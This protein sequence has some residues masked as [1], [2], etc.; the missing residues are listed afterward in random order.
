MP[1]TSRQ[2]IRHPMTIPIEF[3]LAGIVEKIHIKDIGR[4]G[5][6]FSSSHSIDTGE[7]IQIIIP[8]CTPEFDAKG[9]VCWCKEDGGAFLVGVSF[10]QE[11]VSYAVRMVEQVCHIEDYR[12][13]M[14]VEKGIELTSEQAA[15]QWISE[16]AQNFPSFLVE[17]DCNSLK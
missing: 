1:N 12:S 14:K 4:G 13:Q 6:C 3:N 5:L 11:S 8:I 16:Y 15:M 9:V 17:S 10:Q 2:F 7:Q